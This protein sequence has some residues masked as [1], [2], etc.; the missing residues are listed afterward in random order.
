MWSSPPAQWWASRTGSPSRPVRNQFASQ[1]SGRVWRGFTVPWSP[2][3]QIRVV[4][5]SSGSDSLVMSSL[6]S[7]LTGLV[8]PIS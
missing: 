7:A 6:P 2:R 8:P 3:V 1:S 4:A 5:E